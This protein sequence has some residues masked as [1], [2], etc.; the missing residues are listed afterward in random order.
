MQVAERLRN[1][2]TELGTGERLPSEADLVARFDVS[3]T[4]VRRAIKA[5]AE[6]GV[7]DVQ[8]GRGT[9]VAAHRVT[10]SMGE[11]GPFVESLATA[12]ERSTELLDIGWRTGWAV[13]SAIGGPDLPGFGFRWLHRIDGRAH[14]LFD[15]TLPIDIGRRLDQDR[16]ATTPIYKLLQHDLGIIPHAA[17]FT[18]T[19]CDA[20]DD[21]AGHLGVAPSSSLLV[22]DRTTTDRAG[23]II[24]CGRYYLVPELHRIRLSASASRLASVMNFNSRT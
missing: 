1:L 23:E 17:D 2:A 19:A 15:C 20:A 5:L 10:Q 6:E 18:F 3:R 9:F 24:E 21:V 14:A 4:T 22:L 16:V 8:H 11:F 12:G 13:P 7:L